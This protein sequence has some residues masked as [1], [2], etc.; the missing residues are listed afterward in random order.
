MKQFLYGIQL[1]KF[2]TILCTGR[3]EKYRQDTMSWLL[4]HSVWLDELLMRPNDDFRKSPEMKV[5]LIK[6]R[7]K[8][9]S[10]EVAFIVD[11]RLDIIEAFSAIGIPGFQ[12]FVVNVR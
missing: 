7:F 1:A 5:S 6:A 12:A 4:R 9:P 10:E 8:E 11:D 3:P 2:K